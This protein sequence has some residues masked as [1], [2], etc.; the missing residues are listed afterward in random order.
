MSVVWQTLMKIRLMVAASHVPAPEALVNRA[1]EGQRRPPRLPRAAIVRNP[2]LGC[3]L[4]HVIFDSAVRSV[5]RLVEHCR[6]I[7]LDRPTAPGP[8]A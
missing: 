7:R 4:R 6:G 3:S 2:A 8:D 5:K 1:A